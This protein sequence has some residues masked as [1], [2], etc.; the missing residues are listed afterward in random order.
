MHQLVVTQRQKGM[1][2]PLPL[3]DILLYIQEWFGFDVVYEK[4]LRDCVDES[5]I[6]DSIHIFRT[7]LN[8]TVDNPSFSKGAIKAL[9]KIHTRI[10]RGHSIFLR[11]RICNDKSYRGVA[12]YHAV[13]ISK[14]STRT[15]VRILNSAPEDFRMNG[16]IFAAQRSH[17]A[18]FHTIFEHPVE[19]SVH[20]DLTEKNST[21]WSLW[22]VFLLAKELGCT[23][24][25]S[26]RLRA[27]QPSIGDLFG[28][29]RRILKNDAHAEDFVN[30][31]DAGLP[32]RRRVVYWL[33]RG[34]LTGRQF[35]AHERLMA[36]ACR[37]HLENEPKCERE[38]D[39]DCEF[40]PWRSGCKERCYKKPRHRR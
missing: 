34:G 6:K 2:P 4:I 26:A 25:R 39:A 18:L 16:K 1:A 9:K 10:D 3:D 11:M 15:K 7:L 19:T 21:F 14:S 5:D 30:Y 28:F 35:A 24:R 27:T 12:H 37:K 20:H 38:E 31:K 8:T 13:I 29:V 33:R 36:D 23:F 22:T 32:D 17:A 40:R